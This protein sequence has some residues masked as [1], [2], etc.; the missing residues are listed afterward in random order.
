MS[1]FYKS[2]DMR[3]RKAL[4]AFLN[5]HFRYYTMGC[6]NPLTSYANQIK[7]HSLG[8]TASQ[9]TAAYDLIA[10][11]ENYWD[12]LRDIIDDFTAAH[13]GHFTIG[14]NGRSGGYLV[15]YNSQYEQ[16]GYRSYCR[17]CGARNYMAVAQATAG[18]DQGTVMSEILIS[19]GIW[20]DE[21]YLNM[22]AIRAVQLPTPQKLEMIR[23]LKGEMRHYHVDN[24]CHAC[25]AEGPKGRVNY[26]SRPV[27]LRILSTG[28]DEGIDLDHWSLDALR[29]RVRLVQ[30][31]DKACDD[32]RSA[33][34]EMLD[35]VPRQETPA[36]EL[37]KAAA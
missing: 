17:R 20:P 6:N 16:T 30:S 28:T 7:I 15:L 33:F 37:D 26:L 14:C 24:R 34:I 3:S 11:D 25:G 8:L 10:S 18:T 35:G 1:F 22:P 13:G 31:F 29:S 4:M 23:Q 12:A 36:R 27:T 2:V 21:A 32:L 5:G 19:K 9:V